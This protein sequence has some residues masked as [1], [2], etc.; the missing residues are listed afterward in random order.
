[1]TTYATGNPIGSTSPKD[2]FDNAENF[3]H[4][5][6]GEA[7]SYNDRLGNSRKSIAGMQSE[8]E[9]D[10]LDRTDQFEVFLQ[11]SGFETPV[12]YAGGIDVQR[13]TQTIE[14]EEELYRAK[15]GAIPFVTTGS[16]SAD[17]QS[18]VAIGDAALRQA[19]AKKDGGSLVG[20]AQE[21]EGAILRTVSSK[22]METISVL[23]FGAIGDGTYHP[24]SERFSSLSAAQAFYTSVPITSLDDSQDWAAS[25]AADVFAAANGKRVYFP[26]G[27]YRFNRYLLHKASLLGEG[28][29]TKVKPD[30]RGSLI[31]NYGPM[32]GERWTDIDGVSDSADF[33]FLCGA[34]RPDRTVE[35]ITFRC[36]DDYRVDAGYYIPAL[37]RMRLVNVDCMGEFKRA[38]LYQD[39][40]WSNTNTTLMALHP[41][42]E[43]DSGMNEFSAVDCTFEGLRGVWCQGTTRDAA[44]TPFVWSPNGSSDHMYLNCR[45]DP[46]GPYEER[47]VSGAAYEHDVIRSSDTGGRGIHF[48]SC[49]YSVAARYTGKFG[50]SARITYDAH[51]S[52]T[53]DS[54]AVGN[55]SGVFAVTSNTGPISRLGDES[56]GAT[57]L[58]G[59]QVI[60]SSQPDW[61]GSRRV[62]TIRNDGCIFT[63]NL[64]CGMQDYPVRF[65]SWAQTAG[66]FEFCYDNLTVRAAYLTLKRSGFTPALTGT[67]DLGGSGLQFRTIR[68]QNVY[69]SNAIRPDAPNTVPCGTASLAWAGG[70]TQTAFTVTSDERVKS[71]TDDLT[72]AVL[73]AIS[74]VEWRSWHFNDSLERE[75]AGGNSARIHFGVGAQS[76][77]EAFARHGLDAT[78][79]ALLCHDVWDDQ[80]D[81]V[82]ATYKDEVQGD[83]SVRRVIDTPETKVLIRAAGDQYGVR[84]DELL[85]LALALESRE[86][87]QDVEDMTQKI[88]ALALRLDALEA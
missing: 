23:D 50:H 67:M 5:S 77:I 88:S 80:Y 74:E 20:F 45:F 1:M 75:Q 8:F 2:L 24:L 39:C 64:Y 73:D 14:Y 34:A 48:Y 86:R 6:N 11:S 54:Y 87:K 21:G 59:V 17:S 78:E 53:V 4:F 38:G 27:H 22:L 84:Y 58:D 28:N 56:R 41:Y 3:D 79:Y 31:S 57:T 68:V 71:F 33:T 66:D 7:G 70:F 26:A 81:V 13:Y 9:A 43:A 44:T 49:R 29:E 69:L 10:Q 25:W 65:T 37:R 35:G 55:D 62:S 16:W 40:T 12:A 30:G 19:L 82:E 51:Y 32:N 60:G 85:V 15:T 36:A 47:R 52:E 18:L 63:P 46:K 76:I 83:G 42:I 72:D 61:H